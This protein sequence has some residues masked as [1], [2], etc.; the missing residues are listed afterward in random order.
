MS[1]AEELRKKDVRKTNNE[2]NND[3]QSTKQKFQ[4]EKSG[5]Q[6]SI[7]L[8]FT[9]AKEKG[10]LQSSVIEGFWGYLTYKSGYNNDQ[11]LCFVPCSLIDLNTSKIN[12]VDDDKIFYSIS[13]LGICSESMITKLSEMYHTS[14][15]NDKYHSDNYLKMLNDVLEDMGFSNIKCS[16]EV[17]TFY[18]RTNGLLLPRWEKRN[19]TVGFMKCSF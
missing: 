18:K 6:N 11:A 15:L 14:Y 3:D 9:K 13:S 1:F 10:L 12:P 19:V 2:N 4:Q 8:I 7:Q 17:A 5:L 16:A